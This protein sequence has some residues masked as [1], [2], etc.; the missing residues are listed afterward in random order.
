M[1]FALLSF[2]ARWEGRGVRGASAVRSWSQERDCDGEF[3]GYEETEIYQACSRERSVT[4][5]KAAEAIVH[6]RLVGV[7]ADCCANEKVAFLGGRK[8]SDSVFA[9]I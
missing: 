6:D 2:D 8:P 5:G 1:I 9:N 7:L 4:A 3:R